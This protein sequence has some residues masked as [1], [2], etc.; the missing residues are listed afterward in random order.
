MR[1]YWI[2]PAVVAAALM[3]G[4]AAVAAPENA[5]NDAAKRFGAREDIQQISLSPDGKHVAFIEP[6]TARGSALMILD[7]ATGQQTLAT[8]A[9][10]DTEQLGYCEWS[11]NSRLVCSVHIL[12][13]RNGRALTFVRMVAVDLDGSKLTPLSARDS[14][15]ASAANLGGGGIID[16]LPDEGSS[17]VLMTRNFVPDQTTATRGVSTLGGF[18]VE[19]VDTVTLKRTTVEPPRVDAVEYITDGHG[20]VRVMGLRGTDASGY[21]KGVIKYVYRRADSRSWED[22]STV[23]LLGSREIGFD[24]VAVDRDHNVAYGFDTA[25]DH[26]A[27]YSMVLDG[28]KKKALV[29]SRTDA[30]IDQLARIGRQNRVV[31]AGYATDR[32]ST[33]FFDP[34]LKRLSGALGKALPGLPLVYFVDATADESKLLL[35]AGSDVDPGHYYLFDKAS[36]QLSE[37]TPVRPQL[38]GVKLA[39]VK[40]VTYPAADGTLIPAYLT[41]PPGSDGK[42][43]PA[44]VMPHGGPEARDEWGFDWLAQFFANRGYAVLQPNFRGSTGYGDSWFQKNGFQS[45]RTAVGDVNDGGRWLI[46]AGIGDANKLAI[47]GWSYGG[48]AALQSTVVDPNLFKAVVAIAPLTDFESWRQEFV[49]FTNFTNIDARVGHGPHVREGSPAQN[50][51]KITAPVLLFHGDRDQN[52]NIAESRLMASR[53]KGAGKQVELVEFP[54][55]AHQLDDSDVRTQMLDKADTFLR[56]SMN[57]PTAP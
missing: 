51:S 8:S 47:V 9:P 17:A 14:E 13:D 3:A 49:N 41:L 12:A 25:G 54:G 57:M 33:E 5:K 30:D 19:R 32:R 55:L 52:V 43:L 53:L 31:G 56:S 28:S 2:W 36:R 38:E 10:G 35:F 42:D 6:V 29:L 22:L 48:Y 27:L 18:G 50:A 45:W 26:S 37:V 34:E 39:T 23:T 4:A 44:I 11:T 21:D 16:W 24:P 1:K 20:K 7:V 40:S 15:E 46:K